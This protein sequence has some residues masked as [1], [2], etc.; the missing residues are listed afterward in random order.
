MK[1]LRPDVPFAPS[2]SDRLLSVRVDRVICSATPESEGRAA[3][4]VPT[5]A[6]D[7]HGD[8][9]MLF[10]LEGRS[11]YLYRDRL[12]ELSPG[13]L[14]AIAPWE[15]HALGYGA[16]ETGL[17]HLWLH[18]WPD[19][20]TG[21]CIGVEGGRMRPMEKFAAI[22]G[23]PCAYLSR[24]WAE[25][26]A[27]DDAP[28]R[29][30]TLRHVCEAALLEL[31]LGLRKRGEVR[32]AASETADFLEDYIARQH[33]RDCSLAKLERLT[34]YSR[35]HLSRLFHRRFGMT[36]GQAINA[37]RHRFLSDAEAQGLKQRSIGEA[38]G[39]ASPSAFCLWKRRQ[40]DARKPK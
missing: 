15:T 40:A 38:L 9:E 35:F 27:E 3:R 19:Q 29:V 21:S 32:D 23:T 30:E 5:V 2:L 22:A 4:S 16:M 14:V 39:F 6:I 12:W 13:T 26:V 24:R 8:C 36:I 1:P 28:V 31:A 20:I 11:S 7:R 37:S 25:A 10:V 18:M 34:G 17:L 33:G